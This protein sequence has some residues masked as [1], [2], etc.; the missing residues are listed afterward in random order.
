[1]RKATIFL[2]FVL[3]FT[4]GRSQETVEEQKLE[5]DRI[6]T[7][8]FPAN[9]PGATV[10]VARKGEIIYMSIRAGASRQR[11]PRGGAHRRGSDTPRPRHS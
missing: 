5:F 11:R 8:E 1:M 9:E 7:A 4:I 2:A 3:I 6:L 10:L